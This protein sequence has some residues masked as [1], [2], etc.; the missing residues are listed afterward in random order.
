MFMFR[1]KRTANLT[2]KLLRFRRASLNGST[3]VDRGPTGSKDTKEDDIHEL[4]KKLQETQLEML[5]NAV[6]TRG[7]ELGNCVLVPR[8]CSYEPHLLVCQ[9]WR[10]PELRKSDE[11]R[12]LP[13]CG[14]AGD[15]VYSCCNPYHWSRLFTPDI[16]PPP[17]SRTN[18]HRIRPEDRAPSELMLVTRNMFQSLTTS[19]EST[20]TRTDWCKLAYWESQVRVGPLFPVD[21]PHVNIFGNVPFGLDGLSLETISSQR[22]N[23][24]EDSQKV[25][26]KIGL[27]V[28]LSR[29]ADGLVWIYNRSEQPVFVDSLYL[30]GGYDDPNM[31]WPIRL[32]PDYCICVHAPV[33]PQTF[34]WD[35]LMV[36]D[37]PG[38]AP[39]PNS[40]R[41]SFVKGWGKRYSRRDIIS[42][43]CWL[44]ILLAPCR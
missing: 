1:R 42:C 32:P 26:A 29:E 36:S 7:I 12:R 24:S 9:F 23:K 33:A 22:A 11:L 14:A 4:L 44:E 17:Y 16:P 20:V 30:T 39:D 3:A 31:G 5:L 43:P 15:M 38:P 8:E 35:Q 25:R 21:P 18:D 13:Q 28:T 10:W 6:E 34:G 2:R 37:R 19:G 27:G 40:I 41:I